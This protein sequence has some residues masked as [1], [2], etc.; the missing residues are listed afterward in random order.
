VILT[1]SQ[2]EAE[3]APAFTLIELLAVIVIVSM[4]ASAVTVGLAATGERTRLHAAA[5]Q[6]RD[7]DAR[8]RLLGR[9]MGPVVMSV[10]EKGDEVRLRQLPS[11]D[12]LSKVSL[13]K[14]VTGRIQAAGA[15]RSIVFDRLGRTIDYEVQLR[16]SDRVIG[17]HA[18]GLTG[19]MTELKP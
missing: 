7:L 1:P 18:N 13:P 16:S 5:A 19:L 2:L 3:H 11:E 10:V 14:G 12:L 8:G 17:W 15:S 9:S 4:V 6:W